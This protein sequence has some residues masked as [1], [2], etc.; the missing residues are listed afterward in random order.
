M[1]P[2]D[3]TIVPFSSAKPSKR[4]HLLGKPAAPS[5]PITEH[6]ASTPKSSTELVNR[7]E[8]EALEAVV[9]RLFAN[10][11]LKLKTHNLLQQYI[12]GLKTLGE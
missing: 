7:Q 9:G 12:Y 11:Q 4:H 5:L 1:H 8:I 2:S 3:P 6:P 10:K